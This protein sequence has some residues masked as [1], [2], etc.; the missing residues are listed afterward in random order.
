MFVVE[1]QTPRTAADPPP[2]EMTAAALLSAC[3]REAMRQADGLRRLDAALGAALALA[4]P[5]TGVEVGPLVTALTAD[6]QQADRLRQEV[7]GLARTLAL[8]SSV[9]TC[10][11]VVSAA[12]I[13]GCTPVAELQ[14]RLLLLA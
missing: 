6:L 2:E 7:E 8:L 4:R 10:E 12:Q 1:E 3:A 9:S 13:R 5:P 11:G 14:N